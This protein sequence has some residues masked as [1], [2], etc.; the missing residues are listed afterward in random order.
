MVIKRILAMVAGLSIMMAALLVYAADDD[1]M[2]FIPTLVKAQTPVNPVGSWAGSGT[3]TLGACGCSINSI[4][5][6]VTAAERAGTYRI[7]MILDPAN[8]TCDTSCRQINQ[9]MHDIPAVLVGDRLLF[10][11]SYFSTWTTT[12]PTRAFSIYDGELIISGNT[13]KFYVKTNYSQ[14]DTT[15]NPWLMTMVSGGT[16]TRQP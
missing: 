13:A 10:S 15:D 5:F 1:I 14:M 2:M 6:T 3:Y 7:G 4:T 9:T 11:M 8:L 16:L 12:P